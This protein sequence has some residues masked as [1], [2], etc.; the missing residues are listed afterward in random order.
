MLK[1][2]QTVS[3]AIRRTEQTSVSLHRDR[4]TLEGAVARR[5]LDHLFKV[6][7]ASN[8]SPGFGQAVVDLAKESL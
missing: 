7:Y 3:V 6:G 2:S 4:A 1:R 5:W 8:V